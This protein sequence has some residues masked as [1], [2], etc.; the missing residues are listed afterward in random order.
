M[1]E[2]MPK[3]VFTLTVDPNHRFF[4]HYGFW[5]RALASLRIDGEE[6]E[7]ERMTLYAP[8]TPALEPPIR[9][10]DMKVAELS[11]I[12]NFV[13]FDANKKTWQSEQKDQGGGVQ[14]TYSSPGDKEK[15][16]KSFRIFGP[17][18]F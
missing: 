5:D 3:D 14:N 13:Y 1:V 12:A 9:A 6:D 4:A 2:V 18:Q 17:A 16:K 10:V 11:Q 7:L 15:V 8:S